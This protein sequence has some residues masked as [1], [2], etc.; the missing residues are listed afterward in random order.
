MKF[1]LTLSI[2]FLLIGCNEDSPTGY[3]HSQSGEQFELQ[4]GESISIDDGELVFEFDSV[5]VDSRCPERAV[6]VHS[7]DAVVVIKVFN[8]YYEF[9]TS[10][11]PRGMTINEYHIELISLSP[12]QLQPI[13]QTVYT[14]KFIAGKVILG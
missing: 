4:I 13:E 1:V 3:K 2:V 7:G 6:C 10:Q 5:P 9:H 11:W 14:A 8:S 12:R